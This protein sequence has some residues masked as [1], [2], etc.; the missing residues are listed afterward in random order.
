MFDFLQP[1]IINQK[2][3]QFVQQGKRKEM[4]SATQVEFRIRGKRGQEPNW[5]FGLSC[6]EGW[7]GFEGHSSSLLR[8]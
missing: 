6:G 8:S 4:R 3:A 7:G 2:R 1:S 5:Q